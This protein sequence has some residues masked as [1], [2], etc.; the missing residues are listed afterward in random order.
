[1]EERDYV[2]THFPEY[3]YE[4]V[5]WFAQKAEGNDSSPIYRF[6]NAKTRAHFYTISAAER[7]FVIPVHKV[8]QYAGPLFSAWTSQ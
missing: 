6:Y 4:V 3:R 5:S 2:I 1:M 7:D 8:F